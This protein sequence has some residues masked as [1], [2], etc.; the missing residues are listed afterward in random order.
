MQP[1]HCVSQHPVANLHISTHIATE[2]DS[3][4]AAIPMRSA[5]TD[6]RN[7]KHYAHR[8][9]HS[10][11]NTEKEPKRPH[12][13]TC[14]TQEVPF[15]AGCS[16][17]TRKNTRFRAPASSPKQSPC[18]IHAAITKSPLPKVTLSSTLPFVTISHRHHFPKSPH[19]LRHHF[20]KS[21][22]SLCHR[23]PS[24]PPCVIAYYSFVMYCYVMSSLTPPLS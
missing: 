13:R 19:S 10:L 20:P 3:N 4:H 17:F 1:L 22:H 5:T 18:N 6:S 16:H 8:N 14:R 15:I 2:H 12:S 24:S 7:A 21:P 11:Q 9:N 23:L